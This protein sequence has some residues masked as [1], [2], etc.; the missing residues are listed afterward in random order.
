MLFWH[1]SWFEDTSPRVRGLK[2][3]TLLKM[4]VLNRRDEDTR[5]GVATLESLGSAH[6]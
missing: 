3:E 6:V 4:K 2:P 5:Q 1:C